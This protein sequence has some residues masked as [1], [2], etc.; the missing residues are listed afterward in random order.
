ME[1]LEQKS[2]YFNKGKLIEAFQL[3]IE[4]QLAICDPLLK[5]SAFQPSFKE[6]KM[7]N[8]LSVLKKNGYVLV[9]QTG[10]HQFWKY[11]LLSESI[12]LSCHSG[13]DLVH[14]RTIKKIEEQL[15]ELRKPTNR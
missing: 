11:P 3:Y 8:V 4:E 13:G 5:N 9:R 6:R 10:S 15:A 14:C 2:F 12:L 1:T 7:H